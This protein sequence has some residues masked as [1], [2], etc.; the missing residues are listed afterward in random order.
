MIALQLAAHALALVAYALA[1]SALGSALLQLLARPQTMG[2]GVSSLARL[3]SAFI[4]GQGVLAQLLVLA[5]LVLNFTSAL[6]WVAMAL[7]IA[8]GAGA[9]RSDART[10]VLVARGAWAGWRN[11][12]SY[13]WKAIAVLSGMLLV[14]WGCAALAY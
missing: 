7:S 2:G 13:A 10:L 8:L 12:E 9:L 11:E 5:G 1:C 6:V 4:L 3:S 14:L